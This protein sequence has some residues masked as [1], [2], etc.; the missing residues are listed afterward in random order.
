M[1]T[2]GL[3]EE[4]RSGATGEGSRAGLAKDGSGAGAKELGPPGSGCPSGRTPA[5]GCRPRIPRQAGAR[6]VR[7]DQVPPTHR[8]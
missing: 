1:R 7:Q 4:E 5:R 6:D 3:A 2:A 8:P